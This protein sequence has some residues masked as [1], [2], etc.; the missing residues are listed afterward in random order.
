VCTAGACT[1]PDNCNLFE[2]CNPSNEMCET[3]AGDPDNDGLSDGNDPCPYDPRNICYGPIAQDQTTVTDIRINAH[4]ESAHCSGARTDCNGDVW[5]ADF[6]YNLGSDN[7]AC[8]L[9]GGDELC[10]ITGISAL[11]G[12]DSDDTEDLF[13]CE[14]FDKTVSVDELIYDFDLPNG[15]YLINFFFANTFTGTEQVG[16]RVFDISIESALAYDDFDQ[17]VAAGGSGIAVIRSAIATVVDGNG[18]QIEFIH[19]VADPALK[20][21]EILAGPLGPTTTTTTTSTTTT[22]TTTTTMPECVSNADCLDIDFCNGSETCAGNICQPGTDPCPGQMCDETNDLCVDCL[23]DGD[24]ADADFC[25]GMEACIGGACASG[26]DPCPGQL[27]DEGSDTCADCF[28]DGDC[29]DTLFCTGT[30]TC[31]IGVCQPGSDPCIA[32]T[33]CNEAADTCDTCGDVSIASSVQCFTNRACTVPIALAANGLAIADVD[34]TITATSTIQCGDTCTTSAAASNGTCSLDDTTCVFDVSDNDVPIDAFGDG[35]IAELTIECTQEAASQQLCLSGTTL[36]LTDTS[37]APS[38]SDGCV[39]FDC[40][41]CLSGDCNNNSLLDAADPICTVL[42]T[43]GSAPVGADCSCAADCN[44]VSGVEASDPICSVLRQL[45]LF[46]PDTCGG[47][48]GAFVA[49]VGFGANTVSSGD[50]RVRIGAPRIGDKGRATYRMSLRGPGA[51]EIAAVQIDLT[52]NGRVGRVKLAGK[53]RK[54]GFSLQL[55]RPN[56]ISARAYIMPPFDSNGV[57]AIR[58][59]LAL[60]V[61]LPKAEQQLTIENVEL[62]STIGTP[63]KAAGITRGVTKRVTETAGTE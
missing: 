46:T 1:N 36:A 25:N 56:K 50:V 5:A 58:R 48:G 32:S 62:G 11:F 22:S 40:D 2:A 21:I 45:G 26:S 41:T 28:V 13:Q 60:K 3:V 6:G 51:T 24:C 18:L 47:G 29:N 59:G 39:S 8:N 4:A 43:I 17:V 54:R 15:E 14:H 34:S 10:V 23:L 53:L 7:F 37:A 19:G 35:E 31:L 12:C 49:S 42:C 63:V 27:C 55:S 33:L 44:C 20:A 9:G 30:E 16:E 52:S 38:C 61:K 57:A